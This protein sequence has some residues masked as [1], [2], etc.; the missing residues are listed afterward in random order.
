LGY[1]KTREGQIVIGAAVLDDILGTT[2]QDGFP[3]NM[4]LEYLMMF[5]F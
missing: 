3:L 1:L 4:L 2:D 5:Q